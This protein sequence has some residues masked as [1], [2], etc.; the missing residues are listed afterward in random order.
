MLLGT[1]RYLGRGLTFDDIEEGTFVGQETHRQ[2]FH[3][4]VEYGSTKL[5]KKYV[6]DYKNNETI[7]S[8]RNDYAL[9]GFPGAVGS[10]DATHIATEKC[11]DVDSDDDGSVDPSQ[12]NQLNSDGSYTVRRLTR[13]FFRQK[14]VDHFSIVY[15]MDKIHWPRGMKHVREV[16]SDP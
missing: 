4:F 13:D 5:Y 3:T 14:L 7:S 10:F 15:S 9:A 12:M 1:L 6:I 8:D 16:V 2:F 11:N